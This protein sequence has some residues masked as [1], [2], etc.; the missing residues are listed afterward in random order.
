[1]GVAV[2]GNWIFNFAIGFFIPP[3]FRNIT[4]KMFIV[5]GT[6]CFGAAIQSFFTYPET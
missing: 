2:F 5:F 3:G 6:L 1:M 4:W